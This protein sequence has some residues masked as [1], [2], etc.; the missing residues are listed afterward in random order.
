MNAVG[1][2]IAYENGELTEEQTIELFQ[3]LIDSG[4]VWGLQGSYGRS[5]TYL[6][7]QGYCSPAKVRTA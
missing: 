3:V 2:L 4:I 1:L 5:A 7:E 6:I